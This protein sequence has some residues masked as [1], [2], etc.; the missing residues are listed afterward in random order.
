MR[1]LLFLFALPLLGCPTS[2]DPDAP[3]WYQDVAPLVAEN[4]G[5]CHAPG[6]IA[7]FDLVTYDDAKN[8]ADWLA[9]TVEAKTMPPWAAHDTDECSP[10]LPWKADARLTDAEI[11]TFR[12]WADAG[13]PEGDAATAAALPEPKDLALDRVDQTL[14]PDIGHQVPVEGPDQFRCFVLD[15]GNDDTKWLTG[16]QVNPDN[17]NV[18]HH[19]LVFSSDAEDAEFLDAEAAAGGGTFECSAGNPAPHGVE[20]IAAW[21]PGALPMR[22]PEATAMRVP[23][24]W[25]LSSSSCPARKMRPWEGC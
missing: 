19:V 5:G 6:K 10:P 20:L 8:I 7:P 21:A 16:L 18:V 12:A 9:E 15:P 11:A 14:T 25:V 13:A 17:G 22:T 3:T 2:G 1:R 24:R 4:C 23:S